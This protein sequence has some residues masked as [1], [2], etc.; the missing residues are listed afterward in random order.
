MTTPF[1]IYFPHVDAD[2]GRF[3]EIRA[4]D[5]SPESGHAGPVVNT[6]ASAGGISKTE[7]QVATQAA[8]AVRAWERA[9]GLAAPGTAQVNIFLHSSYPSEG[10]SCQAAVAA[11]DWLARRAGRVTPQATLVATGAFGAEPSEDGRML[12]VE[13]VEFVVEKARAVRQQIEGGSLRGRPVLFC[14]PRANAGDPGLAEALADWPPNARHA[15]VATFADLLAAWVPGASED[16]TGEAPHTT[17]RPTDTPRPR[18]KRLALSL[19]GSALLVVAAAGAVLATTSAEAA[20]RLETWADALWAPAAAGQALVAL[21]RTA[22]ADPDHPASGCEALLAA[23]E[24]GELGRGIGWQAVSGRIAACRAAETC[25]REAASPVDRPQG[26]RLTDLAADRVVLLRAREACAAAE[27]AFPQIGRFPYQLSRALGADADPGL[28]EAT[29]LARERARTRSPLA[30]AD[31]WIR[32]APRDPAAAR[33]N[34]SLMAASA[35]AHPYVLRAYADLL[36]CG[37]MREAGAGPDRAAADLHLAEELFAR[38]HASPR[39]AL[40]SG[41]ERQQLERQLAAVRRA[42]AADSTARPAW[43]HAIERLVTTS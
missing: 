26:R 27:T 25:D 9:Q 32:V 37:F 35:E 36:A 5:A 13:P 11:A 7:A 23:A 33:L 28:V 15:A 39:A 14:Y 30:E 42:L 24:R 38:A 40:M 12:P 18:R 4:C 19:V 3:A 17:S 22:A 29:R 21:T 34:L 16:S 2:G 6:I 10:R 20:R 8:M 1:A 41:E 31:H 43:C